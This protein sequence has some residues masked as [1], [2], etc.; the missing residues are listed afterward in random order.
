MSRT[1]R[2]PE[3][4]ENEPVFVVTF[5]RSMDEYS[6]GLRNGATYLIGSHD[7]TVMY[8]TK[9]LSNYKLPPFWVDDLVN[10]ANAFIAVQA[11]P[12]FFSIIQCDLPSSITEYELLF[13]RA[14]KLTANTV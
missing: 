13:Q 8:F 2:L 12:E 5:D 10:R 11:D 14:S 9:K 7:D 6:L 4:L 3:S 1:L